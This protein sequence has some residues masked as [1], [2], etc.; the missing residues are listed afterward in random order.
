MKI[1]AKFSLGICGAELPLLAG[2]EPSSYLSKFGPLSIQNST[3]STLMRD[4]ESPSKVWV[5][6][7]SSGVVEFS[8]VTP[9][10]NIGLFPR[11]E[12]TPMASNGLNS[13][14]EDLGARVTALQ[15][16]IDKAELQSAIADSSRFR[17]DV[18]K[19]PES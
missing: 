5:L 19:Q 4:T 7:P 8:G 3:I 1:L 9:S 11:L 14:L 13:Q 12:S 2:A 10:A 17:A 6:P 16:E 15:P 18:L